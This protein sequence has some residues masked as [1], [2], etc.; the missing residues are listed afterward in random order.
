MNYIIAWSVIGGIISGLIIYS[1]YNQNK[2]NSLY[3]VVMLLLM[4]MVLGP[5]MFLLGSNELD[6]IFIIEKSEKEWSVKPEFLYFG[7]FTTE[8]RNAAVVWL[9]HNG[10]SSQDFKTS[11]VYPWRFRHKADAVIFHKE[12]GGELKKNDYGNI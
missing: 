5:I 12:F 6:K 8:R 7:S 2:T 1:E 10:I 4:G 9:L 11:D 3:S